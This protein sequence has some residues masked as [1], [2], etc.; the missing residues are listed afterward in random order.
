MKEKADVTSRLQKLI[1]WIIWISDDYTS[2][3]TDDFCN[4]NKI[5]LE[6]MEGHPH[7]NVFRHNL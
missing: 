5:Q 7:K 6:K 2:N 1:V 3:D 4:Q